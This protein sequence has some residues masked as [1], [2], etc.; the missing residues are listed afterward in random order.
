MPDRENEYE[1]H[2]SHRQKAKKTNHFRPEEYLAPRQPTDR[3]P[4]TLS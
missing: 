3:T 2:G 1:M 4:R